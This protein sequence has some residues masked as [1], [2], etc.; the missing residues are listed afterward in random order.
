MHWSAGTQVRRYLQTNITVIAK[1]TARSVRNGTSS[2]GVP[3]ILSP[4]RLWHRGAARSSSVF[5][6]GGELAINRLEAPEVSVHALHLL[7]SCLVHMI[8]PAVVFLN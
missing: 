4:T 6:K 3:V 8:E 1:A 2:A 7:Q 5:G